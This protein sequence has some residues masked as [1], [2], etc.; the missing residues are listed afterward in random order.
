LYAYWFNQL[1]PLNQKTPLLKRSSSTE[2]KFLNEFVALHVGISLIQI[3]KSDLQRNADID[4][5]L[6]KEAMYSLRYKNVSADNLYWI[7]NALDLSVS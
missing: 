4:D 5:D 6:F 3:A 2:F 7:F 1:K